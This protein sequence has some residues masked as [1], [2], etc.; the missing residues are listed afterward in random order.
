MKIYPAIDIIDRKVVRLTQGDFSSVKIYANDPVAVAQEFAE[1]GAS[2]LHVIDLDG[3]KNGAPAVTDIIA[4]ITKTTNLRLQVGGGL[5]TLKVAKALFDIGVDRIIIG[6]IAIKYPDG[7]IEYMKALGPGRITIALDCVQCNSDDPIVAINGWQTQCPLS[8]WD[9]L[10]Y[11]VKFGVDRVLCT[12]IERDGM[13]RGCNLGL[14]E[15]MLARYPDLNIQASGGIASIAEIREL[16]QLG[17]ESCVLGKSL[18]EG[19]FA[20]QDALTAVGVRC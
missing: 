19:S 20:L 14:Y 10:D 12:D 3:A 2:F 15:R 1:A 8:L 17:L 11:Y 16:R 4:E 9:L 18:Y 5:R 7:A 6:S 13:K